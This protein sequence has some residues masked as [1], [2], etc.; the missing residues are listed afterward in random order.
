MNSNATFNLE[1]VRDVK[2]MQQD[3]IAM[4]S[5]LKIANQEMRAAQHRV[6]IDEVE[7][8]QDDMADALAEA[9]EVQEVLGRSYDVDNVDEAGLE[10]ELDELE[11]DALNY[12]A[13]PGANLNTP[14]Y[15][16]PQSFGAPAQEHQVP[17]QGYAAPNYAA[18]NAMPAQRY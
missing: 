3:N 17:Q 6:D 2:H 5:N 12:A 8:L 1:Q 9:N 13:A 4:V 10:A 11:E 7:D 16:Q 15:L 18:P 14:T